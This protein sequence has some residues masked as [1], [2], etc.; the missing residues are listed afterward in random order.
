MVAGRRILLSCE[1]TALRERFRDLF[2]PVMHGGSEADHAVMDRMALCGDETG[3][4][5]RVN[6]REAAR[7]R[8]EGDA[9]L[10]ALATLTEL[11]CR[12]AERLMVLHG[13]GLIGPQGRCLLL[14]AP[15][16]SGKTTLAMALEAEVFRLDPRVCGVE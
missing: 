4:T 15:G 7:G 14:A 8:G 9:L 6:G 13:A 2:P 5:L 10:A 16:G 3:W 11:G 12:T 1:S